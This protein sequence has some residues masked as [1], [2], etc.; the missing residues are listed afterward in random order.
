[1]STPLLQSVWNLVGFVIVTLFVCLGPQ[2]SETSAFHIGPHTTKVRVRRQQQQQKQKRNSQC[3]TTTTLQSTSILSGSTARPKKKNLKTFV[4]YLEIECWKH[5]ELRDLEPVLQAVA[6]SC[7]QINRLVQRA[8][9]DDLYGVALGADGLPLED[10]NIQGEVQQQLDVLCNTMML[11]TFCGCS[12]AIHAVASEEEDEPRC[13]SD[14]MVGWFVWWERYG[15]CWLG[16]MACRMTSSSLFLLINLYVFQT[17]SA[18]AMGDYIAV[19]DPI[20]GS[21]NIDASLPVGTIFGIYR[22]RRGGAKMD[23]STF[24]QDGRSLVAAGYCL[25]S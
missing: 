24:L 17:D 20:D 14:V 11:R 8:Q 21:K 6:E 16:E 3:T 19:F 25:Y 12:S 2:S 4:R 5:A 23:A 9:T 7:K 13:C 22:N 15:S 18:F 1:M 10:T